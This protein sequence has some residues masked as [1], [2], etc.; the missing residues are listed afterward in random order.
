MVARYS[1]VSSTPTDPNDFASYLLQAQASKAEVIALANAGGDTIKAIKQAS[2][3]GIV[4]AGRKLAGMLMFISISISSVS[5]RR[6]AC[7]SLRAFIGI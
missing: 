2:E 3:F 1:A 5:T 4:Q 6:R 7:S